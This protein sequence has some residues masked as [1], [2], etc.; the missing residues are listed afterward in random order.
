MNTLVSNF[1]I[2][3]ILNNKKMFIEENVF[4]R[5]DCRLADEAEVKMIDEII[6]D[7]ETY[8]NHDFLRKYQ[9]RYLEISDLLENDN[10]FDMYDKLIG[11]QSAIEFVFMLISPY[12]EYSVDEETINGI[13]YLFCFKDISIENILESKIDFIDENNIFDKAEFANVNQGVK[14]ACIE[15]L[16]DIKIYVIDDFI[17][18]YKEIFIPINKLLESDDLVVDEMIEETI[19]YSNTIIDILS[20][21]KPIYRF[22]DYIK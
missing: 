19:G 15:M 18:K 4:D 16:D 12:L 17:N 14:R 13:S 5:S 8:S 6:E 9:K 10:E 21:I 7:L 20:L 11:K 1:T 22:T 2:I 3:D